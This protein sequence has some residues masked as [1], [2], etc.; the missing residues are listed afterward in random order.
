MPTNVA[1]SASSGIC[2]VDILNCIAGG[3]GPS[4][5]AFLTCG[6]ARSIAQSMV[7]STGKSARTRGACRM[8]RKLPQATAEKATGSNSGSSHVSDSKSSPGS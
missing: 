8:Q 6:T 5:K 2:A 4:K 7:S 3:S 1:T